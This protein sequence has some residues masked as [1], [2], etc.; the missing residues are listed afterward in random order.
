MT[1]QPKTIR[2]NGKP[3]I[4]LN[5]LQTLLDAVNAPKEGDYSDSETYLI[6]KRS[7]SQF[8]VALFADLKPTLSLMGPNVLLEQV[9]FSLLP[10]ATESIPT[11][12]PESGLKVWKRVKRIP[13][14][15]CVIVEGNEV[16]GLFVYTARSGGISF[17]LDNE[18]FSLHGELVDYTDTPAVPTCPHC[19]HEGF[20]LPSDD[21]QNLICQQCRETIEVAV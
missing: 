15:T 2:E 9:P 19:G 3:F 4:A 10:L 12:T 20:Y 17:T 16:V 21:G 1:I 14:S 5:G 6:V 18:R 8:Q 11:N 7:D 13:N